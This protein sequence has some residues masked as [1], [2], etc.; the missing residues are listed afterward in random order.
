MD[1]PG[2]ALITVLASQPAGVEAEVWEV[3]AA[4]MLILSGLAGIE[5]GPGVEDKRTMRRACVMTGQ[6]NP[7]G[8]LYQPEHE[9]F[10]GNKVGG[11]RIHDLIK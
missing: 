5:T 2:S 9:V 6:V 8:A 11:G 1:P 4:L 7:A 3:R 10:R